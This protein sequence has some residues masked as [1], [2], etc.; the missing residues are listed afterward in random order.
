M[1]N[2]L[3][4]YLSD[5]HSTS[6]ENSNSSISNK[7]FKTNSNYASNI[8]NDE[9]IEIVDDATCNLIF[10]LNFLNR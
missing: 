9:V 3:N 2:Q 8:K 10:H 7:N 4:R 6:Q 5:F 1:T